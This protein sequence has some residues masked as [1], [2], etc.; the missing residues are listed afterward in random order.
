MIKN[1]SLSKGRTECPSLHLV[2]VNTFYCQKRTY[3]LSR[4]KFKASFI[5][6][7]SWILSF[8]VAKLNLVVFNK[9]ILFTK[10][11]WI[12]RNPPLQC[13]FYF[14]NFTQ[15][16]IK[17]KDVFFYLAFKSKLSYRSW[18]FA[19][20]KL[21]FTFADICSNLFAQFNL[22]YWTGLTSNTICV[23]LN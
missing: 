12:R 13:R 18:I 2:P 1:K 21:G 7:T 11:K 14:W 3:M 10:F 15:N 17:L 6:H 8:F 23:S 16:E 19:F 9:C 20:V 5:F 4:R 22:R